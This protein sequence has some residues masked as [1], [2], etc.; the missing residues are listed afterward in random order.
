MEPRYGR[1]EADVPESEAAVDIEDLVKGQ[2]GT[3][4]YAILGKEVMQKVQKDIE[5]TTFPSWVKRTPK[6]IGEVSHGKLSFEE[7]KSS[8]NISLLISLICLWG[9]ESQGKQRDRLD[10]FLHLIVAMRLATRRSVTDHSIAAFERHIRAHLEGFKI[11][12]PHETVIPSHH[13]AGCHLGD[14]LRLWGSWDN[15]SAS[16]FESYIGMTQG[17][18]T[19]HKFGECDFATEV[20]AF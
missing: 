15:T 18:P 13:F 10:N 2:G 4:A 7:L 3:P 17:I 20:G 19:N 1:D 6:R 9:R 8:T 11:L 5:D 12:Y 16:P 14:I